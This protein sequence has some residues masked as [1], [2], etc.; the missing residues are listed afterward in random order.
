MRLLK[1]RIA[2]LEAQ[3]SAGRTSG[4]GTRDVPEF[5]ADTI[6]ILVTMFRAWERSKLLQR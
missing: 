2:G 3:T 4:T 6:A 1:A 5:D